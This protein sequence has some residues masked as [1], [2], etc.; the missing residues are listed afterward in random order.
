VT[1]ELRAE[2][3]KLKGLEI[4]VLP[5][6]EE[7]KPFSKRSKEVLSINTSSVEETGKEEVSNQL[8]SSKFALK[9]L[10]VLR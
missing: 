4:R 9:A 1:I 8:K 2:L 10:I 3:R 6:F 7:L 5:S